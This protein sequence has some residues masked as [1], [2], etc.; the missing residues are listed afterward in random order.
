MPSNAATA[1]AR[2][3]CAPM[4][5]GGD[6]FDFSVGC[7]ASCAAYVHVSIALRR[8]LSLNLRSGFGADSRRAYAE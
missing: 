4:M 1:A 6:S 5:D 2:L 7:E 8:T 3:S